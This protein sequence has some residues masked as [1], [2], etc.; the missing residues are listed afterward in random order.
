[1]ALDILHL[2]DLRVPFKISENKENIQ[3]VTLGTPFVTEGITLV[4][5]GIKFV[6]VGTPFVNSRQT[7]PPGISLELTLSL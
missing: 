2:E 6:T 4:T 3:F 5:V 7:P 1:M